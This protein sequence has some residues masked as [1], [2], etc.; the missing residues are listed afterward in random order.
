LDIDVQID[1]MFQDPKF[2]EG[3][4]WADEHKLEIDGKWRDITESGEF[5]K[6]CM[7][8][9]KHPNPALRNLVLQM[10]LDGI[11]PHKGKKSRKYSMQYDTPT[12]ISFML[13][14]FSFISLRR[15]YVSFSLSLSLPPTQ[16]SLSLPHC[17]LTHALIHTHTHIFIGLFRFAS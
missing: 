7:P 11:N 4:R 1:A 2:V 16:L 12:S 5:K 17:P 13:L 9:I 10:S 8:F 3:I 15:R 6:V 14:F